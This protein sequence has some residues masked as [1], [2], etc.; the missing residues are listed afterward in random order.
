MTDAAASAPQ[1]RRPVLMT[2]PLTI[3]HSYK[4]YRPDLDGGIPFAMATLAK[5]T[6][7]GLHHKILVARLKGAGR[8]LTVDDVPV[9]AVTSFG[10]VASTPMAPTY[11][12]A[13]L[14]AARDADVLVVHLP[15]PIADIT[16]PLLPRHAPLIVYWHADI[17]KQRTLRALLSP[18]FRN[19][20]H[21]A[22]RI[23][24]ADQSTIDQSLF[25]PPFADKCSIVPYG[26]DL[27]QWTTSS[28]AEQAAAAALRAKHPRLIVAIGRL[29]PYKGFSV[30]VQ[31]L[32]DIDGAHVAII[33]DGPL[34]EELT[35]QA[36]E[37]GVAGRLTLTGRL[38][39]ADVRAYMHAA[40]V[41]A[42]PSVT[43]AEAFGIVQLEAMATGLP[44]VNTELGTAVSRI[45]R[46]GREGFTVQPH[47]AQGLATALRRIL[48]EPGL[49]ERLGEA[50]RQRAHLE[51]SETTYLDRMNAVYHEAIGQR[52]AAIGYPDRP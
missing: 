15:F 10:N 46:D 7:G 18:A 22:D 49:A 3:V 34:R 21:R 4:V 9:E 35:G 27:S 44:V 36:R 37:L 8:S 33:G 41:F 31:A 12:L 48:D 30:L 26:I 40:R 50:G 19:T 1:E 28:E 29:V 17:V 25:L 45:A 47:D 6:A 13:L 24:V 39:V 32:K 14:R 16:I 11:P 51:Y 5:G 42:F 2:Q 52:R 38:P 43:K 23:V 20:L